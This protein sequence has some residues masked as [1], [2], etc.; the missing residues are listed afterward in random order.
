[1]TVCTKIKILY[2]STD[3]SHFNNNSNVFNSSAEHA[4]FKTLS[5]CVY[6]MVCAYLCMSYVYAWTYAWTWLEKPVST[7]H[8]SGIYWMHLDRYK[9]VLLCYNLAND[10]PFPR[11]KSR[12]LMQAVF[13]RRQPARNA[14]YYRPGKIRKNIINLS[15]AELAQGAIRTDVS[16]CQLVR[17]SVAVICLEPPG[18]AIN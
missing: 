17:F 9:Y 12:H 10:T 4:D 15:N 5:T 2:I 8:S 1:M 13:Q 16:A 11:N 3:T 7:E 6:I 14:R 18:S